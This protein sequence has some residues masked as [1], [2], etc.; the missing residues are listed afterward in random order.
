[1]KQIKISEFT[2]EDGVKMFLQPGT[3]DKWLIR[4]IFGPAWFWIKGSG[5]QICTVMSSKDFDDAALPFAEAL[6]ILDTVE[7]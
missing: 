3:E 1:M 6:E 4:K 5:W 2:R 7:V